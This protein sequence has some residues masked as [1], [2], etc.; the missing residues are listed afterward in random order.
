MKGCLET[1]GKAQIVGQEKPELE[2]GTLDT[3]D[4][5]GATK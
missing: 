5:S 4:L 3:D 2:S 1:G